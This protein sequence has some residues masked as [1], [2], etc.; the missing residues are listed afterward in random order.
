M[1]ENL[2]QQL[3]SRFIKDYESVFKDKIFTEIPHSEIEELY[4]KYKPFILM[5]SEGPHKILA[6]KYFALSQ[7]YKFCLALVIV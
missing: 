7:T 6:S 2:F 5:R 3:Y 1:S 4:M